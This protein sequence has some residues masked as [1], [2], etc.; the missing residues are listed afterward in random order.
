M[1]AGTLQTI[2]ICQDSATSA[3]PCPAGQ[4]P[5]TMQAYVID[6]ASQG[7]FDSAVV[8]FDPMQAASFFMVAFCTTI[9]IAWT[10]WQGGEILDMVRRILGIRN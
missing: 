7:F 3:A 6:P 9:F 5:V 4:A 8:P 2:L 1:P 10:A